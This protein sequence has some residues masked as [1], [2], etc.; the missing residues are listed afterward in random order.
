[1][2]VQR[3]R[4]WSHLQERN[5]KA[6]STNDDRTFKNT[7]PKRNRTPEKSDRVLNKREIDQHKGRST[8]D[9]RASEIRMIALPTD[10]LTRIFTPLPTP[11][12]LRPLLVC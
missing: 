11:Y 8:N 10:P 2:Q 4:S 3:D 5:T 9:D 7:T 1:M 6:R 12:S